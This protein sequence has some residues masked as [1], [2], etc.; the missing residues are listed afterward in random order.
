MKMENIPLFYA[1]VFATNGRIFL[2]VCP[3]KRTWNSQQVRLYNIG[4][5]ATLNKN[6]DHIHRKANEAF[7]ALRFAGEGFSIDELVDK[8]KGKEEEPQLLLGYVEKRNQVMSK[9]V[10]VDITKATYYK[11]RRRSTICTRVLIETLQTKKL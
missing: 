7:E 10:G 2:Q 1:L 9:S 6:P 8:I 11:Y 3:V 5:A 4:K